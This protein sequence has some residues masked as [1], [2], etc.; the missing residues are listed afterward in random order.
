MREWIEAR[1]AGGTDALVVSVD[2]LTTFISASARR[3]S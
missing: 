3:V 1:V 2:D